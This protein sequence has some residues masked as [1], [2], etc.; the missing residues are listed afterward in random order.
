MD[1]KIH[2]LTA[3]F[4]CLG[5]HFGLIAQST[6]STFINKYA[7]HSVLSSGKWYKVSV[8][9]TGIQRLGYAELEALGMDV[10]HINP[11]NLRIYHNGG[12]LL[13]ELNAD[14]RFDDLMEIPIFV[15]G[16][17]DGRFDAN[18]Y[19]LFYARGPVTWQYKS[20]DGFFIHQP[21]AY[22][23]ASYAFITADLGTGQRI[24]TMQ[25]PSAVAAVTINEFQDHQVYEKDQYNLINAGRTY[26]SDILDGNTSLSKSF[27]FAHAK[28]NRPCQVKVNL[29]GRNFNAASFELYVNNV[30]LKT[31]P[32]SVTAPS[33]DHAFAYS[34]SGTVTGAVTSDVIGV[35]LKH[36]GFSGTTSIGYVDYV[37]VNA[38]RA[39]TFEGP[40]M[41]FRNPE[42]SDNTVVYQYKIS[43]ASSNMQVWNVTDSIHPVKVNGQLSGSVYSF[44]TYGNEKNEFIAFNGTS[45]HVPT[46]VGTVDNQ[47]LHGDRNYDYLIVV[48]PDFLE[49]AERL[50]AI[51]AVY[52]PDLRVKI[53]T[54][55]QIYNE[56]SCGAQDVTAIRDYC[57]M[58]YHDTTPLRYLL[59]FGDASYDFKNRNGVVNFVP[60]YEAV[61]ATDIHSSIVTDDFFCFMDENEGALNGSKPD[62]GA[63]RFPVTTV[64]QATQMVT[65]VENYLAND[66]T[67]MAPW[68]NVITF[69]CDDAEAN[70][71]IDHSE[72]F[73]SK[74][75][76]IGGQNLVVDK[77]YLDA[78]PQENTPSGQLAPEVNK[79]LN[80]RVDKGC[81]VLNY[82]GHGGEVQL[83]EERI[84]QRS[85][86]NS[87]RNGP[88]YP[89]MITG[90]CE[91]SRYDDHNRT[92][93]GEYAFLNQ[94]GGMIAM[95]TTARVTQ[96][97]YNKK[98]ITYVYDHLFEIEDGVR[99]RLGD[100]YRKAKP[101]GYISDRMYVFFGDPALRL[102]MPT[103]SVET[104][105]ME[106]TLKALQPA[107]I[108]GVVKDLDG[109]VASSFNGLVYVS[110]YDKETSYTTYGDE[111]VAQR[112][113]ALYNS[114]IFNGKTEVVNGHF[115]IS[116]I[117]PRDISYR[118]GKGMV[119][120]YATDYVHDASGKEE[121]FIIGGFY[122]EAELDETPPMVRL[123]IDDEHFV[124]G[125]VT[126]D[127]PTLLAFV[128]DES[129][130]N[131]TGAGIGHDIVATLSGPTSVSYVLNDFFV[132]DLGC[133][134]KGV[135]NY[136]M[137]NL[138]EGD[139]LLSLKVWD[140]YNN[141]S[142]STIAFKVMNS[143]YMVLEDPM[144]APNPFKDETFF[145][146]GHNQIGNNMDVQI[147][148]YDLMGRLVAVLKE[149]VSGTSTRT[150]PIR[151]DGRSKGGE[152][153]SA[154]VYV[155]CITATNDQHESA[156]ICSKLVITP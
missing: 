117:V 103:W 129:G 80:S 140:I 66:E 126:G 101:D 111:D 72:Y 114:L 56:F 100:V 2:F 6:E 148:I 144:C 70:Q 84:L 113:F 134:G 131:T 136:R 69:L 64:E 106:D 139:Y 21:N 36:V 89:L 35:V 68:R 67:T 37:A 110:V 135:I 33:S 156:Y 124:S 39:L 102:P 87:W 31:F 147:C 96:G 57:R 44:T 90:T 97:P 142:V 109:Q 127:N 120:Y 20:E 58:L 40:E 91:F 92:S 43:G 141:S 153:L 151:W 25:H 10:D 123:F 59:L 62:I 29:A 98:F 105:H 52:D 74:I 5:L 38:W 51:H 27:S 125:G 146:F 79:A 149:Q 1:R 14:A 81:L 42:A 130:I 50:K 75:Q 41:A 152:R 137:Q 7:N 32:I 78:Y 8:M 13:N 145:S 71:F 60:S 26:Y 47:D 108:E 83:A 61:Q 23:D 133:Q 104:T 24:E 15:S 143:E 46:I 34:A 16:E 63:G 150:N 118:F 49:Q 53:V 154:G 121:G 132:A 116:F 55:Q 85:D 48:Y 99:P 128:E 76:S 86:V 93:L 107:T 11:R 19:V 82:V 95:F 18:D 22:E 54:P 30:L 115:S 119:S 17:A 28:T 138:Q 4:L 112:E 12:G 94:Y 88:K 9:E 45:F 122:E 73:A 77:I 3:F 65:K 155:Y